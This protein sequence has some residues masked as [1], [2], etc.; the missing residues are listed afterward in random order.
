[1]NNIE[2]PIFK[3]PQDAFNW[4]LE[5]YGKPYYFVLHPDLTV[6]DIYIPDNAFPELNKQYFERVKKLLS[7]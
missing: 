3:I 6:S 5:D 1:M 7:D 2:L 4:I